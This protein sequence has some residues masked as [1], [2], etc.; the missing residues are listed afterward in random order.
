MFLTYLQTLKNWQS[1]DL[2]HALLGKILVFLFYLK[3]LELFAKNQVFIF[4]E[5]VL[6]TK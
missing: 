3:A 4:V 1:R 5:H 2:G 6:I